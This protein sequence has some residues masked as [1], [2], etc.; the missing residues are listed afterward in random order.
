MAAEGGARQPVPRR[1][2]A[3]LELYRRYKYAPMERKWFRDRARRMAARA[4]VA[5]WLRVRAGA[6]SSETV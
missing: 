4:M 5:L 6:G 1:F 2:N 3:S